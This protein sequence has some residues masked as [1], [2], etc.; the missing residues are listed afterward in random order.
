MRWLVLVMVMLA[1]AARADEA[2]GTWRWCFILAE[3]YELGILPLPQD[4]VRAQALHAAGIDLA[5]TDCDLGDV[6]A[7][8]TGLAVTRARAQGA[9]A[10]FRA[11]AGRL[12]DQGFPGACTTG[13]GM[14]ERI[15][16]QPRTKVAR[17]LAYSNFGAPCM[18]GDDAACLD[19]MRHSAWDAVS[20]GQD[21]EQ[22]RRL[23]EVCLSDRTANCDTVY[24]V[25]ALHS[26]V[27][28]KAELV[29]L[30]ARSCD[31]GHGAVCLAMASL[32]DTRPR[33]D[34]LAAACDASDPD[35]CGS[36]GTTLFGWFK[37]GTG[38]LSPAADAWARGCDLGH[39]PSCHYL[40]HLSRQ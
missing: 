1:G 23:T 10:A 24:G 9:D 34:W 32:D 13:L 29:A 12:C 8:A 27:A 20:V 37:D 40:K 3:R 5:L 35:G 25:I 19:W 6:N 4:K 26:D 31:R 39:V 33:A 2:C 17:T 16:Q 18:A 7:C 15:A 11:A 22:L 28:L 38:A 30:V 21:P 36:L 14:R